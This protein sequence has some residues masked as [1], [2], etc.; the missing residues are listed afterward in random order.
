MSSEVTASG[1][2]AGSGTG[3][4]AANSPNCETSSKTSGVTGAG[5]GVGAGADLQKDRLRVDPS[6]TIPLDRGFRV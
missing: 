4:V 5:G 1:T 3:V 2:L 6:P